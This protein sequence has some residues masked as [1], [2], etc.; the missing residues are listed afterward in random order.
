M[1]DLPSSLLGTAWSSPPSFVAFMSFLLLTQIEQVTP[2]LSLLTRLVS[3]FRC[4]GILLTACEPCDAV[5]H[6]P[7]AQEVVYQGLGVV[8]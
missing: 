5:C 8:E 7:I 1:T 4:D 2:G 3:L 6:I